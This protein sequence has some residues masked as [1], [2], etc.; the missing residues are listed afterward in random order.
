MQISGRSGARPDKYQLRRGL[1]LGRL[2]RSLNA[3][4][5]FASA[6]GNVGSDIYFAL[7]LVALYALGLTPVVFLLAGLLFVTT[8]LSYAEASTILPEAGG[9]STFA[10]VAF[11]DLIGFLAGWGVALDYIL[12]AAISAL[13]VPHYLAALGLPWL[14]Q[15]PGDALAGMAILGL[16]VLLNLVGV[17]DS[18]WLNLGIAIA[19][20]ITQGLIILLGLIAVFSLPTLLHNVHLGVAPTWGEFAFSVSIAV[21]AYTGIETISNLAGETRHPARAIPRATFA[22]IIA[23]LAIYL[24]LTSIALSAMPVHPMAVPDPI[25]GSLFATDLGTVYQAD[26]VVGIVENLPAWLDAAKP[27][28]RAWVGVLAS[29]I[30]LVATNAALL[31]LSRLTFSQSHHDHLPALF[32]RLHPRTHVPWVAIVT[33]G[34]VAVALLIPGLFGVSEADLLGTLLSFGALIGFTAA[35]FA[36]VKLRRM[37]VEPRGTFRIPGSVRWRGKDLVVIPLIGGVGTAVVWCSVVLTH[38]T[39]RWVGLG[40]MLVGLAFYAVYR[41]HRGLPIIGREADLSAV[42]QAIREARRGE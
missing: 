18:A 36:V 40:W 6:Y 14:K 28:L 41:R 33:G 31:G 42:H 7:G 30:L 21:V 19:D 17:N 13:F 11:N 4:A 35:H 27:L 32:G 23:V 24:L 29:T 8:A 20:L 2:S 22:L 25:T 3:P 38:V 39:A 37:N 10:R 5:L 9:C 16:L 1:P 34:A 12:T 26:P 15:A